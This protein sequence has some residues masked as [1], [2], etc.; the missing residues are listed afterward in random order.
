[1]LR[2]LEEGEKAVDAVKLEVLVV[3]IGFWSE[4]NQQRGAQRVFSLFRF[5]ER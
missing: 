3:A 1:M 5:E 4:T 2:V